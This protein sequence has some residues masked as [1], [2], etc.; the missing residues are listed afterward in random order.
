M[1]LNMFHVRVTAVGTLHRVSDFAEIVDF[2][3]RYLL[4]DF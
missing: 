3:T 4:H 1:K 2:V